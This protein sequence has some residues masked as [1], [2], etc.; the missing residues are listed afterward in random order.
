M[1][2]AE[3]TLPTTKIHTQ[4]TLDNIFNNTSVPTTVFWLSILSAIENCR[5]EEQLI[6]LCKEVKQRMPPMQKKKNGEFSRDSDTIDR[7]AQAEIPLDGPLML[8]AVHTIG[9]GNCLCRALSRAFFNEDSFHMEIRARIV[10]EGVLNKQHYLSDDCLERGASYIHHNADLP[11][12]FAT[13]SEYYTP[14]QKLS[15]EMINNIYSMEIHNCARP[16]T[17]MG[18][19][20]LSQAASVL[21][22][23]IHTIYP[24]RSG[25]I[26]NDFH[27]IFFPVEYPVDIDDD[28]NP[29]VIMWTGLKRGTVPIHFVP[30]LRNPQ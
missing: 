6:T 2:S 10:V 7:V 30:L 17:Y 26:R 16:A 3:N 20:Q 21:G 14:G 5:D 29:I 25:T 15:D 4:K 22:V 23:P 1:L 27:R 13:F 8:I 19:W 12:V 18:L 11:T 24:H 9:D 28:D